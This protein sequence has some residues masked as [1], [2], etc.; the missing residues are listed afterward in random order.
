LQWIL[1]T[2]GLKEHLQTKSDY[3]VLLYQIELFIK[4][5][6]FEKNQSQFLFLQVYFMCEVGIT[7][8]ANYVR[9]NA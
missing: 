8:A 7:V 5:T 2:S 1:Q 9:H 4:K 3:P 6:D